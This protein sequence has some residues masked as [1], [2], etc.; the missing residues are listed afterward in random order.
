MKLN[1]FTRENCDYCAQIKIPEGIEVETINLD[2][3]YS[4]FIPAT[5]PVL[6]YD[7]LNFEGPHVINSLLKLV[8]KSQDGDYKG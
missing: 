4:G 1:I 3:D 7:G 2:G 6:Q 8:K 5:V